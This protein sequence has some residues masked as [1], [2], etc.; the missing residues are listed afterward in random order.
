MSTHSAFTVPATVTAVLLA[1]VACGPT[2]TSTSI[3]KLKPTVY[4]AAVQSCRDSLR[5][6]TVVTPGPDKTVTLCQTVEDND[7][8]QK[9]TL[10]PSQVF[11]VIAKGTT[12]RV[13]QAAPTAK[14][15]TAQDDD[16][17]DG[18]DDETD[19]PANDQIGNVGATVSVS[20]VLKTSEKLSDDDQANLLNRFHEE[21]VSATQGIF[22]RSVLKGFGALAFA[23][24]V[25]THAFDDD[26]AKDPTN[27]RTI[28]LSKQS[29]ESGDYFAMTGGS[30]A[31]FYP[32]GT[33]KELSACRA[34]RKAAIDRKADPDAGV[35]KKVCLAWQ[36]AR[37][38]AN[39]GFCARFAR[40]T[41]AWL[42]L[43]DTVREVT[44]CSAPI[45]AAKSETANATQKPEAPA[46]TPDPTSVVREGGVSDA[47][48]LATAKFNEREILSVLKPAC[49]PLAALGEK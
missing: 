40:M 37:M 28:M 7:G 22:S 14:P 33:A 39:V 35:A 19:Q 32:M 17:A 20:V 46:P 30:G 4:E 21:C 42:G 8:K 10:Q 16:Q 26:K 43:V 45:D 5:S 15:G 24:T 23:P 18:S 34:A 49:A 38:K 48:F 36:S 1:A 31:R 44:K 47:D 11:Y 41:S 3:T 29:D 2:R 12:P 27:S 25:T 6:S 9:L 13:K